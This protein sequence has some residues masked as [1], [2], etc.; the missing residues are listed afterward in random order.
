[1]VSSSSKQYTPLSAIKTTTITMPRPGPDPFQLGRAIEKTES[2]VSKNAAAKQCGLKPSTLRKK[3]NE[4][5]EKVHKENIP[6][7]ELTVDDF[8][9]FVHHKTRPKKVVGGDLATTATASKPQAEDPHIHH[10]SQELG[11][12]SSK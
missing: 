11:T 9:H 8:A 4:Y 10:V 3:W 5:Q 2:G 6:P 12:E 7:S 1:M